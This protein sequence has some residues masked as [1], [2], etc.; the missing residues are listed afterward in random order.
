[1]NFILISTYTNLSPV[2]WRKSLIPDLFLPIL[3]LETFIVGI[4]T[5]EY[6]DLGLG[7]VDN[8]LALELR[9]LRFGVNNHWYLSVGTVL[10]YCLA[11]E[12]VKELLLLLK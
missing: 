6:L 4:L 12:L 5:P 2:F 11:S 7:L 1:M 3:G 8:S 9:W 10:R